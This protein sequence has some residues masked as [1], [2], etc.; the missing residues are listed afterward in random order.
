MT[1]SVP[2]HPQPG[3]RLSLE[4]WGDLPED[5]PGEVVDDRLV[6]EEM[7][8]YIHEVIVAWLMR[9]LGN[10]ADGRGAIVGGSEAKFAVARTR[11]RKPDATVFLRGSLKPPRRG[12]VRVPPDIAIEVLSVGVRDERRDRVEKAEEYAAF[13]IRWYWILDPELRKLEIFERGVAGDYAPVLRA[14]RGRVSAVPGCPE[15]E[16]DLDAL[17]AKADE[18]ADG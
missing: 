6:E 10:W 7:P 8:D 12:L 13:G 15:L 4:E 17:W 9:V 16:L 18:L 5:V 1:Q 2:F 11:G 14:E 3:P